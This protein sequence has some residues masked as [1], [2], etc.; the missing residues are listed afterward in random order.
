VQVLFPLMEDLLLPEPFQR[1]VRSAE[2]ARLRAVSLLCKLYLQTL[3][4]LRRGA[5]FT[6]LWLRILDFV[7][8]YMGAD[9]SDTMVRGV[10]PTHAVALRK[11]LSHDVGVHARR[12]RLCVSC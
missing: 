11:R 1:D 10:R 9:G 5:E 8:K 6:F 12:R 3:D 7:Q 2:E 4:R